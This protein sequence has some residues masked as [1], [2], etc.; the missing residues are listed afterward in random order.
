MGEKDDR[1]MMA[2]EEDDGEQEQG[3]SGH[4]VRERSLYTS[5]SRIDD[6]KAA[7]CELC[8][9]FQDADGH[10]NCHSNCRTLL[11]MVQGW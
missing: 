5:N 1:D 9:D 6:R 4:F 3:A 11:D 8:R 7:P 10:S 2:L